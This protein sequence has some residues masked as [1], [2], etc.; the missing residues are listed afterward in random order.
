MQIED[1]D[2]FIAEKERANRERTR[3]LWA[4]I[5]GHT[6]QPEIREIHGNGASPED[7]P[8]P[9]TP[10]PGDSGGTSPEDKPVP[11][12]LTSGGGGGGGSTQK[13]S[14]ELVGEILYNIFSILASSIKYASLCF[15]F[16]VALDAI[17]S[18][19]T[20]FLVYT[21][22]PVY[23]SVSSLLLHFM[24]RFIAAG[25]FTWLVGCLLLV[26]KKPDEPKED[27]TSLLLFMNLLYVIFN[28]VYVKLSGNDEDLN[29]GAIF[30]V[31]F[32][33]TRRITKK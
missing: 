16:V 15:I 29:L 9:M 5:T 7:K 8:V 20:R 6:Q 23:A 1:Y 32:I 3:K 33:L 2:E 14:S 27:I 13:T 30:L 25:I 21:N 17:N 19:V 4:I 24:L 22:V 11:L 18:L 28:V 10:P 31:V 12:I 26:C